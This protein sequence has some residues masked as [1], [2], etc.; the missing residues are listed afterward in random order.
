M[1]Q[2]NIVRIV[3]LLSLLSVGFALTSCVKEIDQPGNPANTGGSS[4]EITDINQMVVPPSFN[5]ESDKSVEFSITIKDNANNPIP[6]IKINIMDHAPGSR[7]I[8]LLSGFTDAS[9]VFS[10]QVR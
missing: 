1:K 3:F 5:Y 6:Y 2:K 7:G 4:G 9:G 10:A 8:V